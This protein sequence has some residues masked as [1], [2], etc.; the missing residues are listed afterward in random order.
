MRYL[1]RKLRYRFAIDYNLPPNSRRNLGVPSYFRR[2]YIAGGA[3]ITGRK[4]YITDLQSKSISLWVGNRDIPNPLMAQALFYQFQFLRSGKL[5][6]LVFPF[7]GF[8]PVGVLFPV[9]QLHRGA[10]TGVFGTF[11]LVVLLHPLF[12][13]RGDAGVESSV[14]A[15][16]NVYGPGS[17]AHFI[18]LSMAE[19]RSSM[20]F[21][22][23]AATAST[24]QCR[25]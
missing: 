16:E 22:S 13:I 24:M 19:H 23:P 15:A 2:K 20:A 1:L 21:S 25:R 8:C 4:A 5:F 12:H 14:G 18:N 11:A 10:A 6:D 7:G 9:D 17:C 3:N